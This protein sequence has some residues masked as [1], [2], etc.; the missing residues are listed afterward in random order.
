MAA[1]PL[2][3]SALLGGVNGDSLQNMA[4]LAYLRQGE[5]AKPFLEAVTAAKVKLRCAYMDQIYVYD[6]MFI[7]CTSCFWS[8]QLFRFIHDLQVYE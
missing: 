7:N 8:K 1:L 3:L 4:L 5:E 6:H 2:Q